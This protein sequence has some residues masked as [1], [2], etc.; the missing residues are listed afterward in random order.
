MLRVRADCSLFDIGNNALLTV[1]QRM[2]TVT[3]D[4]P[5]KEAAHR[6]DSGLFAIAIFKLGK[7]ALFM[8]IGFGALHFLHHDLSESLLR[9][10]AAL[11]F[12][13]ENHFLSVILDRAELVSHHRLK[14]ISLGTFAYSGLAMTEGIGLMLRKTWAEYLT[15]WLSVSFLPWESY[16]LVRHVDWWRVGILSSNLVIVIYLV[17]LLKRKRGPAI[18]QE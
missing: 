16:E 5:N 15:L 14:L 9:L 8:A 1:S 17:W 13:P 7:A 4:K 6:Q 11:R 12:D 2:H 10:I 3:M 18:S